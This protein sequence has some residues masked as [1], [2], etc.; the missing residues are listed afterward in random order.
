M[1]EGRGGAVH[2][3][4]LLYHLW[5]IDKAH[6]LIFFA[7]QRGLVAL[8]KK[9]NLLNYKRCLL[10]IPISSVNHIKS[11]W[12]LKHLLKHIFYFKRAYVNTKQSIV[13]T[14]DTKNW[15][16]PFQLS[17]AFLY[18]P[19]TWFE[20]QIKELVS[21]YKRKAGLKWVNVVLYYINWSR[22]YLRN[23]I[24]NSYL[25]KIYSIF[26]CSIMRFS[27]FSKTFYPMTSRC[28]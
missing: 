21:I 17:V 24:Q 9:G 23:S 28:H 13:I 27:F 19:V 7:E 10:S 1:G 20:F 15:V 4:V 3:L 11:R 18:K 16:S 6:K 12:E 8:K 25:S 2:T 22:M 14:Y 5:N 26:L